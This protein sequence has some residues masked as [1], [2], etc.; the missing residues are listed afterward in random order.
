MKIYERREKMKLITVKKP[1]ELK[2]N[3]Q[4][5][6]FECEE[7]GGHCCQSGNCCLHFIN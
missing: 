1:K 7:H 4:V 5:I 3:G 2:C 6:N